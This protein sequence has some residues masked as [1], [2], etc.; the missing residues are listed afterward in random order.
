[1]GGKGTKKGQSSTIDYILVEEGHWEKVKRVATIDV[2][3][4]LSSHN[5]LIIELEGGKEKG[6]PKK[7]GTSERDKRKAWNCRKGGGQFDYGEFQRL[8][9]DGLEAMEE[10]M[11]RVQR[12]V[13]GEELEE[14]EGMDWVWDRFKRWLMEAAEVGIGVKEVKEKSG[15]AWWNDGLSGLLALK[16]GKYRAWETGKERGEEEE[17]KGR[18]RRSEKEVE[19]GGE[20]GKEGRMEQ[21]RRRDG[22]NKGGGAEDVLQGGGKTQGRGKVAVAE[23][24]EG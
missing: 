23:C 15:K 17:K 10:D 20:K 24:G 7:E 3:E 5:M 6:W 19:E 14:Q 2:P 4:D 1:V 9:K 21:V 11:E 16:K 18:V 8:L 22:K 13:E 12:H